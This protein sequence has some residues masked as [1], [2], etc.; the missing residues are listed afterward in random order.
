[1]ANF[2]ILWPYILAWEGG[3]VDDPSDSGGATN[4]GVTIATWKLYGYD[5]DE[6]NDIDKNDVKLITE[7]DAIYVVLKPLYWDRARADEIEDQSVANII[8]DWM[9]LSGVGKIKKV[10]ELLGVKA[11]GAV[12]SMTLNAIN[13]ADSKKLFGKIWNAR[14][15][16]YDNLVAKRPK[17]KKFYKGWM[18]RLNCIGYGRLKYGSKVVTF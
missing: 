14:K 7:Y 5:K 16:F 18:N 15:T 8:V 6:D 4:K 2:N 1:M 17:D 13:S 9:W 3:Y 11:D 10:Q 12:G